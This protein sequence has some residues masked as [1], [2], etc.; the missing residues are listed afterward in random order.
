M[1]W[2]SLSL[3]IFD[4]I[5]FMSM[6]IYMHLSVCFK[7]MHNNMSYLSVPSYLLILCT[8]CYLKNIVISTLELYF[9]TIWE[10]CFQ[11]CVKWKLGNENLGSD[12]IDTLHILALAGCFLNYLYLCLLY[13]NNMPLIQLS[14]YDRLHFTNMA[15]GFYILDYFGDLLF[16]I[17]KERVSSSP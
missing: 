3:F 6:Q 8:S 12:I 9:Y 5:T 7:L 10:K 17:L 1:Q 13:F 16:A 4:T 15:A 14:N 11:V 2:I